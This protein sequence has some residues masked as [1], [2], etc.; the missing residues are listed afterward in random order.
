MSVAKEFKIKGPRTFN[1]FIGILWGPEDF[2]G[3]NLEISFSTCHPIYFFHF[4]K[5]VITNSHHFLYS[6]VDPSFA[7]IFHSFL[8]TF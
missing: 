2:A 4:S 1:K 5:H 6:T 8:C 7:F 3:S